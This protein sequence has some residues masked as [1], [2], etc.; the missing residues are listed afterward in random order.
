MRTNLGV[1]FVSRPNGS[2][3]LRTNRVGKPK[4]ACDR[5]QERTGDCWTTWAAVR[6][7]QPWH[8]TGSWRAMESLLYHFRDTETYTNTSAHP[9]DLKESP[10]PGK[11][12][13]GQG[14]LQPALTD[15]EIILQIL[16]TRSHLRSSLYKQLLSPEH[17]LSFSMS[18][19][20]ATI[21]KMGH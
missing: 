1:T 20:F 7:A 10:L 15:A 21:K 3:S 2:H 4:Q 18:C 16:T 13:C 19:L 12:K 5:W 9:A 11:D 6:T 8:R 17:L 14:C